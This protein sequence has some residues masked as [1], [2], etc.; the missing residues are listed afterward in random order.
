MAYDT[1]KR[2]K[3]ATADGLLILGAKCDLKLGIARLYITDLE[4]STRVIVDIDK[5]KILHGNVKI[6]DAV[7]VR[8]CK[9]LRNE[10][11]SFLDKVKESLA[12]GFTI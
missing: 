7:L 6:E 1:Y 2:L 3:Y 4:S 8:V 12:E 9:E 11:L 5:N 10:E